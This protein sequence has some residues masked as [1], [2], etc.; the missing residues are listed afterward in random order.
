MHIFICKLSKTHSTLKLYIH[1]YTSGMYTSEIHAT[2][3]SYIFWELYT[4][5]SAGGYVFPD[6]V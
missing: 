2:D 3:T 6:I 1:I 5:V 4:C